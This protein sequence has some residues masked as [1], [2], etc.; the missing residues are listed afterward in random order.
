MC[1]F[2]LGFGFLILCNMM[3]LVLI[4][5]YDLNLERLLGWYLWILGVGMC[6]VFVGG[7]GCWIMFFRD[8]WGE[9]LGNWLRLIS[10]YSCGFVEINYRL[11]EVGFFV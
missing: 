1:F 2:D 4:L 11:E 5:Y 7:L 9:I 10:F 3:R 6:K 8:F